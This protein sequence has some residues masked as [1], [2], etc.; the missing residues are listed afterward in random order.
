MRCAVVWRRGKVV[1]M[2][3]K[4][5]IVESLGRQRREGFFS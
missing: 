1:Q 5:V 3:L 2:R 4:A